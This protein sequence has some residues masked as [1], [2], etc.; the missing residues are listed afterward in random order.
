M[1]ESQSAETH[2]TSQQEATKITILH[3]KAGWQRKQEK[4]CEIPCDL[5]VYLKLCLIFLCTA[6]VEEVKLKDNQYTLEHV[7]AFGMYNYLHL[8]PWYEESVFFVDCKGR[9]LSLA[10]TLVSLWWF[11]LKVTASGSH[12][13]VVFIHC[14]LCDE[15]MMWQWNLMVGFS[16]ANTPVG[17]EQIL[18]KYCGNG[19]G[20]TKMHFSMMF[21]W[22]KM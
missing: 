2:I 18:N 12:W 17:G 8:D 11:F 4:C 15:L 7:R 1:N 6:A 14:H 22:Y 21:V 19:G 16:A 5:L 9:V 3:I 13:G 10:V 20:S